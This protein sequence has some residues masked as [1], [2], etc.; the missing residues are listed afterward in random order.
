MEYLPVK[1]VKITQ[2]V[3]EKPW[4]LSGNVKRIL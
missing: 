4:Y 3:G 2:P 1:T